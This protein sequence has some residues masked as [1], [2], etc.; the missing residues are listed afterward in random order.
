MKFIIWLIIGNRRQKLEEFGQSGSSTK[1]LE[2]SGHLYCLNSQVAD[3]VLM[4][5]SFGR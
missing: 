1:I 4:T 5:M 2:S 3:F